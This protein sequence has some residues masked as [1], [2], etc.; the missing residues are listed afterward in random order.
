MEAL[1][2]SF[3]GVKGA[4]PLRSD[5]EE[6]RRCKAGEEDRLS[7]LIELELRRRGF[8][9]LA[10][11]WTPRMPTGEFNTGE[12]GGNGVAEASSIESWRK[13]W[14]CDGSWPFLCPFVRCAESRELE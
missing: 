13:E 2:D 3:G 14:K 6:V 8:G 11:W 4:S 5:V 10:E 12:D 9:D 7:M 1:R